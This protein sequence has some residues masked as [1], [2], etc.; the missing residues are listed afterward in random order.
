MALVNAA[1]DFGVP[2][3]AEDGR[4]ACVGI[5]PPEVFAR[6]REAPF[7]VTNGLCIAKK[8]GARGPVKPSIFAAK[9]QHAEFQ[10]GM[11]IPEEDLLVLEIE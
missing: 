1:G 8:E 10:G 4:G 5:H 3:G 11:N 9:D 2:A 7:G 6:Q